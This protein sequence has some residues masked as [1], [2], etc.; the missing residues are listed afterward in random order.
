[1]VAYLFQISKFE[2]NV[3]SRSFDQNSRFGR[4]VLWE[5]V[6]IITLVIFHNS[7]QISLSYIGT[8][9]KHIFHG[10]I[11]KV[12]LIGQRTS[13]KAQVAILKNHPLSFPLLF[14]TNFNKEVTTFAIT[15]LSIG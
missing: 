8:Q 14:S 2:M 4:I 1:M 15:T 9:Q 13:S 5:N 10:D 3:I 7:T 12:L 11:S 6:F